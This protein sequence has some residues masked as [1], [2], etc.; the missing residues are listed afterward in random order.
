MLAELTIQN[1]VIVEKALL[2]PGEGLV[3]IS[4]ETGAGKSLLLDAIDLVS[5][6]RARPGLV[7]SWGESA[8]VSAVFQ[9]DPARAARIAAVAQVEVEDGQVIIR[10]RVAEGG[11]SQSWINDQAVT[12]TTLREVASAL[13][14]LHAQHEPI[15]LAEPGVQ[16][17]LLDAFGGHAEVVERYR[18]IHS[19]VAERERELAE[20]DGIGKD[21]AKEVDY[22][23]FQLAAFDELQPQP[24]ELAKLEQRQ[25]L[26]SAAGTWRDLA[27]EAVQILVDGDK[28]LATQLGRLARRLDGAPD[29]RL[30]QASDNL[31]L[32]LEQIREA[33]AA[34]SAA[35]DAIESDPETLA[36]VEA[37][38]DRWHDL[39]RKH[40]PDESALFATWESLAARLRVVRTAGERREGVVAAIVET[41]KQRLKIGAELATAR[42]AT[43]RRLADAVHEHLAELGMPKARLTLADADCAEPNRHGTIQQTFLVCTNPG[44]KPGTIRDIASGGEASR[45]MLALSAALA[46]SD[47][48]P[49]LVF[50]E[51][52]SG[53]GGRLGVAIGGKLAR[54]ASGRTVLVV[55]HTPQVAACG[56]RQY[57]VRKHQ[58][59]HRTT[60]TVAE[61]EGAVRIAEIADMLGGGDAALSQSRTLLGVTAEIPARTSATKTRGGRS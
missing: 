27:S 21:G 4:G 58:G 52:D 3:V 56:H 13:I 36:T 43:F 26:L 49:L 45:L 9:V 34:C 53:V 47:Q 61:V 12:V 24:G 51:V 20:I 15:R 19:Q 22:L 59:D 32:A 11:R 46:I 50:D 17:E 8:T 44:Q 7:G 25:S 57:V 31:R 35:A 5:G 18:A 33:G 37:R 29:A 39:L 2:Q 23:G 38:L 55:T 1:L 41:R 40:G 16:L 28:A 54:L 42:R 48:M 14:D 10:R 30:A 6:A 60:V